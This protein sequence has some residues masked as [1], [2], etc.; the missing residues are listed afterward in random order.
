[1]ALFKNLKKLLGIKPKNYIQNNFFEEEKN[2][3]IIDFENNEG[4]TFTESYE[5]LQGFGNVSTFY[6]SKYIDKS[7]CVV[8]E[9]MLTT[10]GEVIDGYPRFKLLTKDSNGKYSYKIVSYENEMNYSNVNIEKCIKV[11]YSDDM[12]YKTLY[13]YQSDLESGNYNKEIVDECLDIINSV[14]EASQKTKDEQLER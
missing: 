14:K 6:T 5:K 9:K 1:M 2:S 12:G 10:S 8:C 11:E 13:V 7:K 3:L 4:N